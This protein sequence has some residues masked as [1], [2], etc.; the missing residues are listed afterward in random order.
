MYQFT[1]INNKW[2][3]GAWQFLSW[4]QRPLN[5]LNYFIQKKTWGERSYITCAAQFYEQ[6]NCFLSWRKFFPFVY[7]SRCLDFSDKRLSYDNA[8]T[9]SFMTCWKKRKQEKRKRDEYEKAVGIE[10]EGKVQVVETSLE[11]ICLLHPRKLP[12]PLQK[13]TSQSWFRRRVTF[14]AT[15]VWSL[16]KIRIQ[17][18]FRLPRANWK[19][20]LSID[21]RTSL[22]KYIFDGIK[23]ILNDLFIKF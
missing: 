6:R 11:L 23:K 20:Q 18:K 5:S 3:S 8:E 9:A 7:I 15:G 19:S 2:K 16:E 10:K 4:W 12:H 1:K 17:V 21:Q 14:L 22:L 13:M